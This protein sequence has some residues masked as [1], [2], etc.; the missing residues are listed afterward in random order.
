MGKS[1]YIIP[2]FVP[3]EGCPHECVFCNQRSITGSKEIVDAQ[4]VDT[5]V[6]RYLKTINK[7][8]STI[9]ISFFGGTFTAIDIN[10][11]KELLEVALKYKK[12]G[13][14]NLIRLSTRPDYI[15][16][17]ILQN[18]KS[19]SVDIIELGVQ[20]M[21]SDVL[22]KSGRGHTAEDVIN[23]SKLIKAFGF[24]L[25]HQIMPGLPGDNF[26]KDI[27]TTEQ[28]IKLK[29]SLCRIYPTLVVRNTALERL[30]NEGKYTPYTL[31]ETVKIS[32]LLYCMLLTNNIKII[33]IGLQPTTEINVNGDVI[34]GP[35]HPSMRELVE[36]S[37]MNQT[38][39]ELIPENYSGNLEIFINNKDISKLYANKKEFFIDMKKQ[40][41]TQ[42]IKITQNNNLNIG[43]L[44]IK[45]DDCENKVS[46]YNY[47]ANKYKEGNLKN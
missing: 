18:L 7:T 6:Q 37:L 10:K 35:F 25:G 8:N 40:L 34:A 26:E 24:T 17:S 20:S 13:K 33:R 43:E 30:Y 45:Y 14:I 2:I 21:D 44:V 12:S 5:T 47:L 9:E 3:H 29:P 28:I 41:R 36:G 15:D 19:Y 23:A 42:N 16:E 31:N 22:I 27:S 38:I 1:H 4:F 11:Q 39:F 46:L 32:K